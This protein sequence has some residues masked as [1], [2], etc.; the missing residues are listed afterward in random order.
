MKVRNYHKIEQRNAYSK[1]ECVG[2]TVRVGISVEDGAEQLAM[3]I[4]EIDPEGYSPCRSKPHEQAI[5]VVKGCGAVKVK[6]SERT[7]GKDDV[8]FLPAGQEYQFKN[9]GDEKLTLV[10]TIPQVE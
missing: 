8:L 4:V 3:R 1:E 2:C 9:T 10:I 5:F 7:I 6:E